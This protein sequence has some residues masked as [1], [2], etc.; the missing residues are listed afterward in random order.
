[1]SKIMSHQ[2]AANGDGHDHAAD[3]RA[4]S[5]SRQAKNEGPDDDPA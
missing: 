4:G 5:G 3:G 1:M 2:G